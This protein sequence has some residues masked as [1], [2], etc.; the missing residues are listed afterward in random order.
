MKVQVISS[1]GLSYHIFNM[2]KTLNI[3]GQLEGETNF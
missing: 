3:E 2:V 1:I